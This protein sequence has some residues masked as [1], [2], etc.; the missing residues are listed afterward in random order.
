MKTTAE[1]EYRLRWTRPGWKPK[2]RFYT[3]P[4]WARKKAQHY[5]AQG[6]AVQL[7]ARTVQVVSDWA[8]LGPEE[9]TEPREPI[10]R[11]QCTVASVVPRFG[12]AA[13]CLITYTVEEVDIPAERFMPMA[14]APKVGDTHWLQLTFHEDE[15]GPY[16]KVWNS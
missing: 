6:Y 8:P 14:R 7:D 16:A 12:N 9:A 5:A 2:T 10:K 4:K 1:I 11:Y 3:R 15:A 13:E